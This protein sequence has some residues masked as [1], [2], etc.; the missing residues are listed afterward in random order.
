MDENLLQQV[1]SQ[2]PVIDNPDSRDY[3]FD[4]YMK[5]QTE[6]THV[7]LVTKRPYDLRVPFWQGN[8]W[9]CTF[10]WPT[11]ANNWQ[12]ALAFKQQNLSYDQ[13]NPM[14]LW[15]EQWTHTYQI[16]DWLRFLKNKGM[17]SWYVAISKGTQANNDNR[18]KQFKQSI[19]MGNYIDTGAYGI[20]YGRAFSY[21][22]DNLVWTTTGFYAT[23]SHC[24]NLIDY[25]DAKQ[26]FVMAGSFS[27]KRGNK[28]YAYISYADVWR[29]YTAYAIINKDDSWIFAKFKNQQQAKQLADSCS[30]F[31]EKE[32]DSETQNLLHL[33]AQ[34]LREEYDISKM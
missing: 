22:M 25:D 15:N 27:E 17:I 24:F 29:L 32:L 33:L 23:A 4:D 18:V 13:I 12:Q 9:A 3:Q 5:Q 30:V 8:I 6:E 16:L 1:I 11:L 31:W 26:H 20:D 21:P 19:D 28:W 7:W 2:N 34:K 10:F 14:E